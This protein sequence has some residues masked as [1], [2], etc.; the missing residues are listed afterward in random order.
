LYV[1]GLLYPLVSLRVYDRLGGILASQLAPL[2]ERLLL[3][4]ERRL[5]CVF[6]FINDGE[7]PM[8]TGSDVNEGKHHQGH[9]HFSLIGTTMYFFEKISTLDVHFFTLWYPWSRLRNNKYN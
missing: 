8:K 5:K 4:R 1:V 7:V 3:W 9:T 6:G 2:R